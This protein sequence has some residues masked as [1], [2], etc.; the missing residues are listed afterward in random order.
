MRL[1]NL[2]LA[3]LV[4]AATTAAGKSV[5]DSTALSPDNPF[6]KEEH[7]ALR[8][9]AVRQDQGRALPAARSP[10]MAEQRDEIDAIAKNP[11]AP[12]FEN[13]IV[14]MERSGRLLTRVGTVFCNLD[15]A[16]TNPS[17]KLETEMSPK[18][19]A[20]N[21]SIY[22]DAHAVR[23]RRDAVRASA[24]RSSSTRN[25]APAR[26]LPPELRARGRE[27]RPTRTRRRSSS[28]TSEISTLYDRVPAEGAQGR[29]CRG[30]RRRQRGGARRLSAEQIAAAAEAAKA[31]GLDGKWLITLQNTTTQPPL[32]QLEEPRAARAD[33]PG[34]D[35]AAAAG[36]EST[37]RRA[38]RRS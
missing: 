12:T 5:N 33:L 11:A 10:G 9:A 18:L 30:G 17:S 36:G 13:T 38:S 1:S 3:T 20:H 19:S 34:L 27:A 7:A 2:L 4:L 6:A 25:R 23:A 8:A 37:R 14:A 22:L 35:R 32:A 28:S 31:R 15:S 16:N 29:E 26:A 21:D 24:H